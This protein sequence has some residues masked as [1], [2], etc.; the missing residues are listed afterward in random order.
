M[1]GRIPTAP[2]LPPIMT[3]CQMPPHKPF[4]LVEPI[5]VGAPSGHLCRACGESVEI[6]DEGLTVDHLRPDILAMIVRGDY[7]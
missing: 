4:Y 1:G 7:G 6:D 5:L 2:P 3:W